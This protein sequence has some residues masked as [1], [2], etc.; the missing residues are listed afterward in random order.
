MRLRDF[1]G[2]AATPSHQASGI[3]RDQVIELHGN[4][5]RTLPELWKGVR[6][7]ADPEDLPGRS[8]LARV[9]SVR[10]IGE[11]P[12][13]KP[14]IRSFGFGTAKTTSSITLDKRRV[15][16][17]DAFAVSPRAAVRSPTVR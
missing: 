16:I 3:S 13:P 14:V 17:Q 2:A 12:V 9:C 11:L 10:P 8:D 15:R 7:R 6:P 1:C 5:V 4:T